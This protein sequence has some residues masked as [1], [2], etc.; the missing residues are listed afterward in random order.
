MAPNNWQGNPYLGAH[1]CNDPD[2]SPGGS[3]KA[4]AKVG[5]TFEILATR[6]INLGDDILLTYDLV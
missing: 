6:A 1:M 5:H 3:I 2:F 4:D